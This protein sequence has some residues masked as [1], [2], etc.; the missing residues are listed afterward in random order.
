MDKELAKA[1]PMS[2][3]LE[4]L[5]HKPVKIQEKYDWYLSPFRIE[6]TASFQVN[7]IKNTWNDYGTGKGGDTI[8]LV[9]EYLEFCGES[10]TFIDAMR[11]F[12]NLYGD[13]LIKIN[14]PVLFSDL[15]ETEKTIEFVS[16]GKLKHFGL[17]NYLTSRGI[18]LNVAYKYLDEVKVINNKTMK[19][20]VALGLKNEENGYELRTP[21]FKSCYGKKAITFIRGEGLEPK[22]I[23]IFEGIFDFLSVASVTENG[24]LKNDTIILNSTSMLN[25]AFPFIAGF[26]YKVIYT[27]M[28]NDATGK[29]ATAIINDFCKQ[30]D[31]VISHKPMGHLYTGFNDV[32]D[33]HRARGFTFKNSNTT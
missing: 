4:K 17:K 18:D 31:P 15:G 12:K 3:I 11:W 8:N 32:N 30:H 1:I 26:G 6:K 28:D 27:W 19:K 20:I 7:K 25:N 10:S 21:I 2:S 22:G 23:N 13:G 16:S 9:C 5:G 24:V 29:N 33:C 14:L